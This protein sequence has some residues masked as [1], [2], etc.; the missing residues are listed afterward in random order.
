MGTLTLADLRDEVSKALGDRDDITD[1]RFTRVINLAQERVSRHRTFEETWVAESFSFPFTTTPANDKFMAFSTLTN[2]NPK[3]IISLR[4]IDSLSSRK[5]SY[6][7]PRQW[8][9]LVPATEELT[10]NRPLFYTVWSDQFEWYP[11][12]DK[13]YSGILRMSV[14]PTALSADGDKSLLDHKDDILINMS[15]SWLMH[16][17]GRDADGKKFFN[18]AKD[19]LRDAVIEES[20]R[21]DADLV[22]EVTVHAGNTFL[23]SYWADPFIRSVL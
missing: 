5:V 7:S 8:D 23:G 17:E 11:V 16:S 14:W 13:S 19:M 2:S 18:I 6:R 15:A 12:P 9:S 1:A 4:L 21:P 3:E 10:L 22:P 20:D